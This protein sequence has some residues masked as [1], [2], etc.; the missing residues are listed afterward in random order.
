MKT[1]KKNCTRCNESFAL[2]EDNFYKDSR[3]KSGFQARCK[4][5]CIAAVKRIHTEQRE[6]QNQWQRD[7]RKSN[8]GLY[9][10]QRLQREYG[11]TTEQYTAI[12]EEQ[13]RCCGICKGVTPGPKSWHIDHDHKTRKVR[14]ILCHSCNTGLGLLG[15]TIAGLQQAMAYLVIDQNRTERYGNTRVPRV[16]K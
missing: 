3:K 6:V 10:A 8:P 5:C 9:F 12:W 1:G 13:G 11:I 14:G 2:V 4:S 15:D 7:Y 16:H